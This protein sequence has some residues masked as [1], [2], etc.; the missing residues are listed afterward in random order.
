MPD[1]IY[2]VT[3]SEGT[4][5]ERFQIAHLLNLESEGACSTHANGF[6]PSDNYDSAIAVVDGRIV[7]G[8][9]A[10]RDRAVPLRGELNAKGLKVHAAS[11]PG[12]FRPGDQNVTMLHCVENR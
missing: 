2:I 1:G 12:G 4:P 11:G 8:V 9:I 3:V 5:V 7:G 6:V 10:D